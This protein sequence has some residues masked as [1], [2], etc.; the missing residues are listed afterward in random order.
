MSHMRKFVCIT[1]STAGDSQLCDSMSFFCQDCQF[2]SS[3]T[4][5]LKIS[6]HISNTKLLFA[7]L[8]LVNFQA[9]EVSAQMDASEYVCHYFHE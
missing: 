1:F 6:V 9:V 8:L 7:M 5:H 2:V 3:F 4:F